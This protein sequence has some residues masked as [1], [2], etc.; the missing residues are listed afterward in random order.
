MS[1]CVEDQCFDG[2]NVTRVEYVMGDLERMIEN[3]MIAYLSV[4]PNRHVNDF[5]RETYGIE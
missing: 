2:A 5:W 1:D 3:E 4:N